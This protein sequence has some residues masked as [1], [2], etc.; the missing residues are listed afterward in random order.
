MEKLE[1]N[2]K[3][4]NSDLLK[5]TGLIQETM[6]LIDLYRENMSRQELIEHVLEFNSLAKE[7]DNRTKDI[8]NL[9]FSKRYLKDDDSAVF[10]IQHLR[11]KYVS[12]EIISQ[13][14]F[15]YTCRAN[16]I[17]FDFVSEI[18]QPLIKKVA[19]F[20]PTN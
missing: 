15:I 3:I 20:C 11:N 10:E 4:Y 5:G 1:E 13:I 9:V 14:L 6:V 12:L 17:L 19:P 16:L 8:V 2:S 18:I 7:H